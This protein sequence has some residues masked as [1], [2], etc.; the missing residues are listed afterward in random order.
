MRSTKKITSII[1]ATTLMGV[2]G[3]CAT[4]EEEDTLGLGGAESEINITE[5]PMDHSMMEHD[6]GMDHGA[7]NHDMHHAMELGEADEQ[8]ELRFI[9]AMIPHHQGALIMAQDA[10][11]NSSREEINALATQIVEAQ[12]IEILEMQQWRE[13]WY[14][15]APET[16]TAWDP[17]TNQ[18]VPMTPEQISAMRMDMDLGVGDEE[19]DLRFINAMIPHHQA[20]IIMA[21]DAL[22][23]SDNPEI[24]A[25]AQNV[26]MTQQAE[27]DQLEQWRNEWY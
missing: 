4:P 9:D 7:M 15:E 20:A 22:E 1:M 3:A 6:H 17:Q 24:Q 27:I 25:L 2:L 8:Y 19:F 14:P 5:E 10:I 12:Q 23:K 26:I 13:Q 18:T 21:E 11:E 16:P